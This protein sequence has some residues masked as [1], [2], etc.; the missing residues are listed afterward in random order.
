MEKE[1]K[2]EFRNWCESK[3]MEVV[4]VHYRNTPAFHGYRAF[5]CNYYGPKRANIVSLVLETS[6]IHFTNTESGKE[7]AVGIG[8]YPS[9]NINWRNDDPSNGRY[10]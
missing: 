4:S 8:D 2:E 7:V 9:G 5:L 6:T 3:G 10:A 1:E